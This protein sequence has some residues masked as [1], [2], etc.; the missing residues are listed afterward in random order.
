M[1]AF[2]SPCPYRSE[3][4]GA[5]SL[6]VSRDCLPPLSAPVRFR[7]ALALMQFCIPSVDRLPY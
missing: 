7:T 4:Q 3:E 6:P 2:L 1:S 5:W